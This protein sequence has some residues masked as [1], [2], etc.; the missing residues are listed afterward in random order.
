MNIQIVIA[1][2]ELT[3]NVMAGQYKYIAVANLFTAE[4]KV[5]VF[6][7]EIAYKRL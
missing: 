4:A 2:E 1:I 6:I 5:C 7:W 3:Q